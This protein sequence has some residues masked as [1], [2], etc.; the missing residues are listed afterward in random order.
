MT[1]TTGP[2]RRSSFLRAIPRRDALALAVVDRG[3]F[4]QRPH[5]RAIAVDPVGDEVP[6]HAVPL[7]DLD[8]TRSFVIAAAG[9]HRWHEA[10]RVQLLETRVRQVEMLERPADLV[11]V[12]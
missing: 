12:H 5:Q 6:L 9:L 2:M 10:G 1:I 8:A 7:L 3:L 11:A 4:Q